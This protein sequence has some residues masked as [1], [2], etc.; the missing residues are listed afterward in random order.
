MAIKLHTKTVAPPFDFREYVSITRD[1]NGDPGIAK[2]PVD[3]YPA[4]KPM[5]KKPP[6]METQWNHP[7][8]QS[9][10]EL[11]AIYEEFHARQRKISLEK[12]I[13]LRFNMRRIE[14]EI[15]TMMADKRRLDEP[16]RLQRFYFERMRLERYI[17]TMLIQKMGKHAIDQEKMFADLCQMTVTRSH[18]LAQRMFSLARLEPQERTVKWVGHRNRVITQFFKEWQHDVQETAK[19]EL[20][21]ERM[22]KIHARQK[23]F[24]VKMTEMAPPNTPNANIQENLPNPPAFSSKFGTKMVFERYE[25]SLPDNRTPDY[26]I[27]PLKKKHDPNSGDGDGNSTVNADTTKQSHK[28]VTDGKSQK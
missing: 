1:V 8:L 5:P 28:V 20:L 19:L 24:N 14:A 7:L 21:R 27:L 18:E 15:E 25:R 2:L 10:R 22:D 4:H 17:Q 9:Y 26:D 6:H 13:D 16:L 23:V 12:D 11:F 3:R